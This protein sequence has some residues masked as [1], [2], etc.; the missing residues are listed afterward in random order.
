MIKDVARLLVRAAALLCA[1]SF[2]SA[3]CAGSGGPGSILS[4]IVDGGAWVTTIVLTNPL[5]T[6]QRVG[7]FFY[8]DA[9]GGA[10]Q[11]WNLNFVEMTPAQAQALTVPPGSTL[12]LH[13]LGT[14]PGTTVGWGLLV[15]VGAC[16]GGLANGYA[17]FT[18]RIPGRTDQDGTGEATP[19]GSRYLV[20]F[21]NTDGAVTTVAIVNPNVTPFETISV[22]IRKSDGTVAQEPAITLPLEGHTSFAFPAQFPGTSG[23]AGLA[24]FYSPNGNFCILAL[25]FNSGGAFTTAPVY[26]VTGAPILVSIP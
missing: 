22:A 14:D 3:Q 11:P 17:I 25:R 8:Q 13:T 19:V 1:V 20:P 10:T 24:E 2:A 6:Q 9:S 4:Q 16:G 5:S 18:Q 15:G 23:R 26:L 21:D 12:F 7:L